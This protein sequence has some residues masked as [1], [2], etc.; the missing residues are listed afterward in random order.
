M[1]WTL[2][3]GNGWHSRGHFALSNATRRQCP[4]SLWL[5][6]SSVRLTNRRQLNL[7]TTTDCRKLGTR[8]SICPLLS[9]KWFI[10][11]GNKIGI[12]E[13]YWIYTFS[14][15]NIG[16]TYVS[17]SLNKSRHMPHVIPLDYWSGKFWSCTTLIGLTSSWRHI[18]KTTLKAWKLV[19]LRQ[20]WP[21]ISIRPC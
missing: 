13:L 14:M 21:F 16:K 12:G 10:D 8:A 4:P 11:T 5:T 6:N 3:K 18:G 7:S 19:E 15:W 20:R 17:D 1:K 9:T 2:P